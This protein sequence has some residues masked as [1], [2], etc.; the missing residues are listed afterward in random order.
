M[1]FRSCLKPRSESLFLVVAE[2]P[3]GIFIYLP[4]MPDMPIPSA[5]AAP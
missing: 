5:I 2:L 1:A 3:D 4:P